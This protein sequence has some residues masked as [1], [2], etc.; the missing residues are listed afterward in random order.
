MIRQPGLGYAGVYIT[1]FGWGNRA[2]ARGVRGNA[3]HALSRSPQ[4]H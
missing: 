3:D 4:V 2:H 1:F